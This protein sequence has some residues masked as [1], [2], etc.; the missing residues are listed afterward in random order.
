MELGI[1]IKKLI[2]SLLSFFAYVCFIILK[3]MNIFVCQTA[4]IIV[5]NTSFLLKNNLYE[6][7][8]T[9]PQIQNVKQLKIYDI[10]K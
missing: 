9:H 10:Q 2:E 8:N 7:H 1:L 3:N 6:F 4:L 5:F